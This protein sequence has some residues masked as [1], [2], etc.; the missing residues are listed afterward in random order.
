M[1]TMKKE[2]EGLDGRVEC[3]IEFHIFL[4]HLQ[5]LDSQWFKDRVGSDSTELAKFSGSRFSYRRHKKSCIPRYK[6]LKNNSIIVYKNK[7]DTYQ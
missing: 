4:S 7:V 2:V 1:F 6:C 5:K 3:K